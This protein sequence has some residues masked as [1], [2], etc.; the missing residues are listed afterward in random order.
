MNALETLTRLVELDTFCEADLRYCFVSADKK[1]L[2]VDGTAARPNHVEDF[3][4]LKVLCQCDDIESYAGIGISVQASHVCAIDVDKCFSKPFDLSSADDRAKDI[5]DMFKDKAYIEFSFS[6]KGLRVLF[7]HALIKDYA[8][9]YYIKNDKN[10]IEYYQP[11]SSYRYVTVT[12]MT[13]A[14]NKIDSVYDLRHT[15]TTFLDKYMQRPVAFVRDV[16]TE[17]TET[18]SLDE[19]LKA[20][21]RLYLKNMKFQDLWFKQAPGSGKNESQLDFHLLSELF[22][23]ITQDK[24]LLRQVFEASPYFKSKDRKHLNKWYGQDYRYYDFV[25][26]HIVGKYRNDI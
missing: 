12:G 15:L 19:L 1:P 6:G 2:K 4:S 11:S 5:I 26:S 14:D 8:V 9:K 25:Y 13:I 7:R 18:R 16:V 23:Q 21:R 20:V 24:D 22:E 3:S 10:S 17:K